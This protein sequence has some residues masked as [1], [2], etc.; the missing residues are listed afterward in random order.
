MERR[1][2]ESGND[3][4]KRSR[5][6]ARGTERRQWGGGRGD[7]RMYCAMSG[8]CCA[9]IKPVFVRECVCARMITL[10]TY[11]ASDVCVVYVLCVVR[12]T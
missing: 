10:I 8:L 2:E 6:E 11:I 7:Q 12:V 9:N 3:T 1:R 4:V 5:R